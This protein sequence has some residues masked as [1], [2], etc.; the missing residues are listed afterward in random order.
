MA[1]VVTDNC[2]DCKY[3]T[4]AA[5]CPV[6]AFHEG[7]DRLLINPE[8]CIDCN[9]CVPECPVNAIYADFEVPPNQRHHIALAR[10]EAAKY[11]KITESK[12]PLKTS[13]C[14]DPNAG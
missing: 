13:R 7:P 2:I 8:T 9:A 4:C 3:T 10:E 5:V 11:P 14:V 12:R 6:E 1:Y